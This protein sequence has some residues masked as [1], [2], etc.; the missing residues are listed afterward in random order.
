MYFSIT[1]TYKAVFL[2]YVMNYYH[3]ICSAEIYVTK[4]YNTS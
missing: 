2:G 4:I 1:M 3:K